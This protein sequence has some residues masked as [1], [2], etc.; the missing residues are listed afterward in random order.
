MQFLLLLSALLSAVTGV[1]AGPRAAEV[2][3]SQ[4]EARIVTTANPAARAHAET[5]RPVDPCLNRIDQA[6]GAP[7]VPPAPPISPPLKNV[8]LIE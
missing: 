2:Q 7:A 5:Q 6:A 8:C 3:V 1:F 4:A